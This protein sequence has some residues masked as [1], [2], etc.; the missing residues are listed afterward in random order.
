MLDKI[1]YWV[2]EDD[3]EI[4]AQK[5][6][7]ILPT[8][9]LAVPMKDSLEPCHVQPSHLGVTANCCLYVMNNIS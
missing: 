6:S 4:G 7:G 2:R 9:T 1:M 5:L 8:N 3:T